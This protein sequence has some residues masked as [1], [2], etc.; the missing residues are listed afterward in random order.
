MLQKKKLTIWSLSILLLAL[1]TTSFAANKPN[2]LVLW[3][4]DVGVCLNAHTEQAPIVNGVLI[5]RPNHKVA[6]WIGAA[7]G[8]NTN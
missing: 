8:I 1:S 3:G 5:L 4:D 2:I 6:H 7:Q